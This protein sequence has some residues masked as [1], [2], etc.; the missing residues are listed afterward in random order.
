MRATLMINASL[1]AK[2]KLICNSA[3]SK[4]LINTN[5][6]KHVA[7]AYICGE[8]TSKFVNK[9]RVK[10]ITEI[11]NIIFLMET[12]KKVL[13]GMPFQKWSLV[14]HYVK[15]CFLAFYCDFLDKFIA[16]GDFQLFKMDTDSVWFGLDQI[17]IKESC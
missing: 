1:R 8:V 12:E 17:N 5:K 9:P 2:L 6:V 16:R 4:T 3:Y 10:K 7:I 11:A 14:Y 13:W 15:L